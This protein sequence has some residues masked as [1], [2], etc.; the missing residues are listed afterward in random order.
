MVSHMGR[1]NE[2]ALIYKKGLVAHISD[3]LENP[4]LVSRITQLAQTHVNK[5]FILGQSATQYFNITSYAGKL[6]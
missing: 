1:L 3:D 6:F 4:V 2:V 5:T